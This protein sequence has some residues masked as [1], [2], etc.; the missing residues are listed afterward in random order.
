MTE[1]LF[2]APQFLVDDLALSIEFYRDRLGFGVDFEYGGFYAGVSR[3]GARLHL[4]CAPKTGADRTHRLEGGH[5]DAVF[6]VS[7]V[8]DLFEEFRALDV[9]IVGTLGERA[10]GT[11]DFT[12]RDPG[13]YLLCFSEPS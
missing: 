2:A 12:L 3:G 9:D 1:I 11:R 8:S 6:E 10:W 4:K 7:G 5:L 13:G